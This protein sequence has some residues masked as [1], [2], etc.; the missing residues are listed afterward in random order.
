MGAP[1]L[2]FAA[3]PSPRLAF[4]DLISGPDTGLGDQEGSGVIVT[5]WGQLLGSS[6]GVSTIEFCDSIGECR[7]AR[8]YYWKNADATP[9]SGPANLFE[10][11]KMQEIAISIP[12]SAAGQG[13]IRVT[14]D[15]LTDSLPFTVRP[16]EIYHVKNQGSDS[17]GDGSWNNPWRT[18]SHADSIATA[19]D[20]LYIHDVTT[21]EDGDP[22]RVYYNNRGFKANTSNQFAYVSYPGTRAE[23]YGKDGVHVYRSTGIVT[24]KLSVFA[25]NCADE[26][27]DGCNQRGTAGIMPSD[28]GRVIG[29]RIT[30]RPGMC[31]S[32]QAGA[33]SGGIDRVEGSKIF[34]N[35]IHDYGCPNTGK[36]HHTTYLT[37]RDN[38]NDKEIESWELGWNYLKDNWAKNGLHFYDENS[39]SGS[40]CGDL[41]TDMR[42]HNNVVVNQGGSG[43]ALASACGWSQDTYIYNNVLINVGLPVDVDCTSTCG[44]TGSAIEILDIGRGL[45]GNVY[46]NNNTVYKWDTQNQDTTLQSCIVLRGSG[47]NAQVFINDNIC[48]TE[49]DKPFL[50]TFSFS[51]SVNHT[52][53]LSGSNNIW[54]TSV[55]DPQRAIIPQLIQ[56]PVL[57]NP[58]LTLS[59]S[60]IEVAEDSVVLGK[61]L[62]NFEH[63]IYGVRREQPSAI[64]AVEYFLFRSPPAAIQSLEV[65]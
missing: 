46:L 65:F 39:G 47:D 19:G 40:E 25:S 20:T 61:S 24:S 45:T 43:I 38:D 7:D 9:P 44:S 53:N 27:L 26:S 17:S 16:G 63:D 57:G 35:H 52:D 41:T 13:N 10:S 21:I 31:A 58:K 2:V 3:N 62:S 8:V 5:I 22:G 6:Q 50:T 29:N 60:I 59:G 48:Y 11:H 30:D 15:G 37:I 34:G 49:S 4:S 33:I 23:L 64:G 54:F 32:G 55:L 28:W 36:L 18:V 14:V 12:E 51:E 42:V 1:N 56:E